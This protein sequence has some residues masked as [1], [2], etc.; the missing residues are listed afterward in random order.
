MSELIEVGDI[1]A[2]N[3]LAWHKLSYSIEDKKILHGLS[4]VVRSGEM[5]GILG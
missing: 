5:V 2:S 3:T 1:N 4:G